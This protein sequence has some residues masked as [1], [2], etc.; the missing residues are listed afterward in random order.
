MTDILPSAHVRASYR[1]HGTPRPS[2]QRRLRTGFRKGRAGTLLTRACSGEDFTSEMSDA[3]SY[4]ASVRTTDK[5]DR[6]KTTRTLKQ[7]L[8]LSASYVVRLLPVPTYTALPS[9]RLQQD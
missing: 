5:I 9:S 8:Y 3:Y 4:R 6:R 1:G 7:S 2:R